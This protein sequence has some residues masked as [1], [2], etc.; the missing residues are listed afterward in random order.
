MPVKMLEGDLEISRGLLFFKYTIFNTHHPA[1]KVFLRQG[2][3]FSGQG[4]SFF[5]QSIIHVYEV[6][7]ESDAGVATYFSFF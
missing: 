1:L 7:A 2:I 4:R 6:E 3:P 5:T